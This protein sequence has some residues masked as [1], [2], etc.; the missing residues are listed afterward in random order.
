MAKKLGQVKIVGWDTS[1]DE[2]E[3]VTSGDVYALVSQDPFRMG[4]DGVITAVKAIRQHQKL[5]S[6]DTG[7]VLITRKNLKDGRVQQMVAPACR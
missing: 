5:K 3:G 6:Q 4:H 1:P 7:V 2:L